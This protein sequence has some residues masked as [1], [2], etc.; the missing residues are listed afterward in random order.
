VGNLFEE[1]FLEEYCIFS[2]LEDLIDTPLS[3]LKEHMQLGND[4]SFVAATNNREHKV[5]ESEFLRKHVLLQLI[6]ESTK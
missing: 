5:M 1:W 6:T 2:G 4:K 3:A